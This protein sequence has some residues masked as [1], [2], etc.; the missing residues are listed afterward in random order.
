MRIVGSKQCG[1]IESHTLTDGEEVV[2]IP[3]DVALDPQ[4][5]TTLDAA[6]SRA[7]QGC[8][9][10]P[11]LNYRQAAESL[12]VSTRWLQRRV[13][14][15]AIPHYRL[16]RR[17]WWSPA[18]IEQIREQMKRGDVKHRGIGA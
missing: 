14:E 7:T 17:V 16:G 8:S 5:I 11:T 3:I 6:I 12:G 10:P 18:Q 1:N 4:M 9:P 15:S 2:V 13:S